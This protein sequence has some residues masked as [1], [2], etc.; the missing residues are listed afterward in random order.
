MQI[1]AVMVGDIVSRCRHPPRLEH[2][3]IP[4]VSVQ[5]A[6]VNCGTVELSRKLPDWESS[7]MERRKNRK[8]ECEERERA[9]ERGGG[10][11]G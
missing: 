11:G 1:A 10:V 4:S 3:I 7:R 5:E 2:D 8:C 9:S 6:E